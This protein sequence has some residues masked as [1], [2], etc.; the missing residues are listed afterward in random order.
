MNCCLMCCGKALEPVLKD[1]RNG[2]NDKDKN[3]GKG[4]DYR[5]YSKT[6]H[7]INIER[8]C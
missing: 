2:S 8:K 4:I 6:N 1:Y 5:A 3:K 7:G